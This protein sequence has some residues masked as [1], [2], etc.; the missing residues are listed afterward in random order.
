MR[1]MFER[2]RHSYFDYEY[3]VEAETGF[4]NKQT[5]PIQGK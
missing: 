3:G 1:F 5:N 2:N 4:W